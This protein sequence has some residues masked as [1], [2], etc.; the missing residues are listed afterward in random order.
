MGVEEPFKSLECM[1]SIDVSIHRDRVSSEKSVSGRV[2]ADLFELITE[3]KGASHI[4]GCSSGNGL[5]LFIKPFAK[6]IKETATIANN[7]ARLPWSLMD[8]SND[9]EVAEEV[10][11]LFNRPGEVR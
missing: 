10:L 3:V 7:W 4:G 5:K 1:F 11:R 8:L 6:A 9:V 2:N